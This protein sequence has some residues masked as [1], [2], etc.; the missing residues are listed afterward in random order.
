MMIVR[1][2]AGAPLGPGSPR[3]LS[4]SFEPVSTPGGIFTT[5][6]SVRPSLR[7]TSMVVSPPRTAVRNGMVRWAS[8]ARPVRGR[9]DRP[10]RIRP[11][12][13]SKS[14]APACSSSST[15]CA[16]MAAAHVAEELGE[17]DV[18]VA[19]LAEPEREIGRAAPRP[20]GGHPLERGVAVAI[21]AL[22]LL[23][24]GQ[25]VVRLLDF[26]ELRLGRL[27]ARV[28][29][30]MELPRQPAVGL[31]DGLGRRV[32]GHTQHFV[33]IAFGHR[34]TDLVGWRRGVAAIAAIRSFRSDN[35]AGE[36]LR[37]QRPR[38][39]S[40]GIGNCTRGWL[41]DSSEDAAPSLGG[42]WRVVPGR[43][44]AR[45]GAACAQ[46]LPAVADCGRA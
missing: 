19:R 21:V 27:V 6:V 14:P 41:S 12:R 17:I 13:S 40:S 1:S 9:P 22:P 11:S 5:R 32:A 35:P 42:G 16:T 2:P 30:G 18:L 25:D 8:I 44:H 15:P 20:G 26:L 34:A 45:P 31:L 38:R 37:A 39:P 23:R 28:D 36:P 3:P 4:R 46:L 43:P 29:V 24:V 10:V 33:I 7:C